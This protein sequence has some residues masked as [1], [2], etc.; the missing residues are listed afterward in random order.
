MNEAIIENYLT[1]IQDVEPDYLTE[2][3]RNF[4]GNFDKK[5]LKRTMDKLHMSFTKGDGE[6]FDQIAKKTARIAKLPKYQEVKNFMGKF[7]D[8]NPAINDSVELSKKVLKNTFKI[9]DKAKLEIMGSAVGMTAWIKSKGGRTN[10]TAATKETL[11]KIHTDVMNI[12]DTG[13]ENMSTNTAEEEEMQKKLMSQA[14][15]QEKQELIIVLIILSV[16][17]ASVVWAGVTIWGIVTSP[18]VIGLGVI[19]TMLIMVAKFLMAYLGIAATVAFSAL[20]FLKSR[21]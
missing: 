9:K 13:F 4:V 17:A 2:G 3:L 18:V 14:K 19:T 6:T 11:Q 10:V 7:Q 16:L 21:G 8:E 12:Y 5:V 20:I 15:K 1:V